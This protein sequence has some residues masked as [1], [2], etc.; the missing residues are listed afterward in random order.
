M[1]GRDERGFDAVFRAQEQDGFGPSTAAALV[2]MLGGVPYETVYPS[3]ANIG[4]GAMNF[5][6]LLRWDAQ[7]RRAWGEL[8]APLQGRPEWRW[9]CRRRSAE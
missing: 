5:D 4:R 8:S 7:K 3:Y 2:S 9:R 6:S 1:R